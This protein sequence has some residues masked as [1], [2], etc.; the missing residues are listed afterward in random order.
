L[1]RQIKFDF[2]L[3]I[4]T[5]L[6]VVVGTTIIYSASNFKAKEQFDDS[7]YFLKRQ[8][9]R[10]FIGLILMTIFLTVDYHDLQKLS[11]LILLA[12]IL[13]LIYVLFNGLKINGSRRSLYLLGS[14][15]QPSELAK[16][17]LIL[18]L[19]W[20][21]VLKGNRIREFTNGLLPALIVITVTVIPILLEPDLGTAVILFLIAIILLFVSN[22]NLYHLSALGISSLAVISIALANFS[23]QKERL[24]SFVS[25]VR[26]VKEPTWQILQS[27]ICFSN[28]GFWG[29]GLGNSRQKLHFL[30]QPFT[31]FIYAIVG[32]EMG[33]IGAFIVLLLFMAFLWRGIWI[34]L[35]APDQQGK[36][37]AVGI[38]AAV[39]IY[40][41]V[42]IAIT[43][44][45]LPITGIPL[46]FISYG[47]SS[48]IMNFIGVGI[49][50]NISRQIRIKP[51][52]AL[53]IISAQQRYNNIKRRKRVTRKF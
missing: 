19:S 7:N 23:Y 24:F 20:F 11:W 36:L 21:L 42:N 8:F 29:L 32:E 14:I 51:V 50:L 33:I 22:A 28:G 41:F 38:T 47:G 40:A 1:N 45:L 25:T 43:I 44:N 37:L 30:P 16:Y 18:F 46:P 49:L 27:L 15:F 35:H 12:S 10:V 9:V 52:S 48:L 13:L 4:I 34:A 17:A 5:L 31:D 3:L 2:I 26:G 39:S 6:L 53:N